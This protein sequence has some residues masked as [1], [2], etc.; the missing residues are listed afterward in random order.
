MKSNAIFAFIAFIYRDGMSGDGIWWDRDG[1]TR[2]NGRGWDI[3]CFIPSHIRG[4]RRQ[5][6]A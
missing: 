2:R 4:I 1:A 6:R 5:A 3:L